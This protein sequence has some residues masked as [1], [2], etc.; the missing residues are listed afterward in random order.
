MPKYLTLDEA[1]VIHAVAMS[2][3]G[4]TPAPLR[5][6]G[7]LESALMRPQMAAHYTGAD[8]IEQAAILAVGVSEAQAFIDGNKRTAYLCLV[9]F[10]EING[11]QYTGEPKALARQ[12]EIVAQHHEPLGLATQHFVEWLRQLVGQ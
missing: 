3:T 11:L 1:I 5:D 10:L 2:I 9:T 6:A 7:V 4:Y 12:I 8:I